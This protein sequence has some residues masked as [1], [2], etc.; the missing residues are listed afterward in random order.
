MSS[1]CQARCWP[2]AAFMIKIKTVFN[3]MNDSGLPPI[4]ITRNGDIKPL[5]PP[6]KYHSSRGGKTRR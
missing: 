3:T 1:V 5:P 2:T 6:K 4:I